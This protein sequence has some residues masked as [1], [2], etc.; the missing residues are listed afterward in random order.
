M[1]RLG[2]L[3]LALPLLA[4]N[5]TLLG[6][7]ET[8]ADCPDDTV[9]SEGLCL[10]PGNLRPDGGPPS[11]GGE[12]TALTIALTAPE[13][14]AT[15][16]AA[17]LEVSGTVS[18]GVA[19]SVEFRLLPGAELPPTDAVAG[20]AGAGGLWT[21]TL[22]I[23][24]DSVLSG[25]YTLT[26]RATAGGVA[27]ESPPRTLR[28]DKTG[29]EVEFAV[30]YPPRSAGHPAANAFLRNET[31]VVRARTTDAAGLADA[32]PTLSAPGVEA[33]PGTL[34]DDGR[35]AF[36]FSARLPPLAA[37]EAELTVTLTVADRLGNTTV[38]T[39]PVRLS[40][41]AFVWRKPRS[42][43]V[44]TAPA[45]I[46]AGGRRTLVVGDD[47]GFVSAVDR[48]TG[49]LVWEQDLS[50]PVVGHVAAGASA[51]YAVTRAGYAYVLDPAPAAADHR[52]FRCPRD[53][54]DPADGGLTVPA[55]GP[56]LG[57]TKVPR[58]DGS[59]GED[60]EETL[61]LV[62]RARQVRMVRRSPF[63]TR[64]G[65][66]T[67]S[68]CAKSTDLP[69]GALITSGVPAIDA[70]GDLYVGTPEG[71]VHKVSVVR[72][73]SDG[74][75]SLEQPWGNRPYDA[76]AGVSGSLSIAAATTPWGV[77][78]PTSSGALS[79]ADPAS[80]QLWTSSALRESLRGGV[81]ADASHAYAVAQPG[82]S[83]RSKLERYPLTTGLVA[84]GG[85]VSLEPRDA[86][87]EATPVVAAD[88]RL[89]VAS[90]PRLASL[91]PGG[92]VEWSLDTRPGGT[93][94]PILLVDT[95]TPVLAC[96]GLLYV[97]ASST[98]LS[99]V[100]ALVTDSTAG[101][102]TAGWPRGGHDVRNTGNASVPLDSA[103]TH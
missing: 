50:S 14:G 89:Y 83:G 60:D 74:T 40:R 54:L 5:P 23:E 87:A 101:L 38:A 42:K 51:L 12:T 76:G 103:C 97:V 63:T 27:V 102:A 7:C 47:D 11:D 52:L 34:G 35:W 91:A 45:L 39:Q 62:T 37:L 4:C 10:S 36:E 28:V 48:L 31:V 32:P 81:V 9:C 98:T 46:A 2:L 73:P 25:T 19:E 56:A 95:V 99:E 86:A 93:G 20:T 77:L 15:V 41:R 96:D 66:A 100:H 6:E 24:K 18:G 29:P 61:F 67:F 72:A 92:A 16:G 3:A 64:F 79:A 21:G 88:G 85:T 1:S 75:L 26:A 69:F 57:W 55:G 84:P 44:T 94:T 90:G 17:P 8:Q 58:A 71:K 82:S 49:A 13:D 30:G 70:S 68:G 43:P 65:T 59:G 33:L 22:D 53:P 78:V 80:Q